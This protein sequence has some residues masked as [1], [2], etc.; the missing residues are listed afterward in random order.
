MPVSVALPS[1]APLHTNRFFTGL[2][3]QRNPLR[4]AAT[5]YLQEKYAG[6]RFDSLIDGLNSEVTARLT[7][8]RRAGHSVYNSQTFPSVNRFHGFRT[9]G[10]ASESLRVMADCATEVYDATGPNTKNLIFTK[11]AGAGSSYFQGVGNTL[12]FGN[13]VDE[14]KWVQTARAWA[15]A[16]TFAASAFII[17]TN[18][19]LQ[20]PVGTQ[21]A[22][23]TNV[24]ISANVGTITFKANRPLY[25]VTGVA[26]LLAGLTT[27][28]FLNA[29]TVVIT[30]TPGLNQI[31]FA[32]VHGDVAT[33][34]DTGTVTTT[35]GNTGGVAPAWAVALRAVTTDGN[36]QWICYGDSV[37]KWGVA[38]PTAKPLATN[39]A[40]PSAYAS[41][42]ALTFYNPSLVIVDSNGSIQEL[43]TGGTTAGVQPAWSVIEGNTTADNTAT[44]THRGTGVRANLTAYA[45]NKFIK[46]SQTTYVTVRSRDPETGE[47]SFDSYPVTTSSMMKCTTA[48]ITAAAQPSWPAAQ[49]ATVKDGTVTWTNVGSQLTWPS[50]GASTLVSKD[51]TVLDNNGNKQQITKAGKSGAAQPTWK[52]SVG[53]STTD[54]TATW[55]CQGA[56]S[57]ANTGEWI[58]S[59]AFKAS[60]TNEISTESP[61]S[62]P[63]TLAASSMI[64]LSGNGSADDQVD[65]IQIYRTAQDGSTRLLIDEISNPGDA[66]WTWYDTNPDDNL[67]VTI[68]AQTASSNDPPPTGLINL[69]YHL[70]RVWGSVG[71]TLYYSA[72]PDTLNGNGNSCFPPQN[73]FV[74]PS[75]VKRAWSCPIGLL[76]FTTSNIYIVLGRG[77]SISTLYAVTFLEGIGLLGYDA[78][79]VHGSTVFLM[80]TSK[81]MLSLDPGAGIVEVGFPIGD[82]FKSRYDP[83]TA[84]VAWH[85]GT[86]DDTALFVA[87]GATGWHRMAANPAP[88][89]GIVWSPRAIVTGACKAV[90]SLEVTPGTKKLLVGPLA[91]G[92]ILQRDTSVNTDNAATFV[93]SATIGSIMM[94]QHGQVAE[95]DFIGVDSMRVGTPATVSLLLGEVSGTFD[96]MY[97]TANDPPLLPQS[98]TLYSDRYH[99]DQTQSHSFCRHFQIKFSFAAEDAYNE[100]LSYTVFGALFQEKR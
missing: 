94:A 90:Q 84:Y 54:S 82:Q 56:F 17:D 13:G 71:N 45:L 32:F 11:S 100:L 24:N 61:V 18:N 14:K 76:V 43:T 50:I 88:E 52:T 91:A 89:S 46:V 19:K 39:T 63:I 51:Q 41:W 25:Y 97:P 6:S 2:W 57:A 30:S 29:Q 96:D 33:V 26:V 37:Q 4:D 59:Y 23:I 77:T 48:G 44:W 86:S 53:Q 16:T 15:A 78:F 75:A 47:V 34:S 73:F 36:T 3:T 38:K 64:Q 69:T 8:A 40:A 35:A 70:G 99:M 98:T 62:D 58:Y 67:I 66:P 22:D 60:L 80:T 65:V 31:K 68:Q 12:Y 20:V 42:V 5:P 72:G 74:F 1:Y 28:A 93:W 83:S 55:S 79:D 92:Q 21:S 81:K 10:T 87:D 7:L 27:N 49:G 9:F 95:L 85:E